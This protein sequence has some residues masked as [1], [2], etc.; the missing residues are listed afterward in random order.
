MNK[1]IKKKHANMHPQPCPF[2]GSN[3]KPVQF[4]AWW[5]IGCFMWHCKNPWYV[6]AKTKKRAIKAWNHQMNMIQRKD[7]E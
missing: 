3:V 1:R 6:L 5:Q 2:C 4:T 7:S